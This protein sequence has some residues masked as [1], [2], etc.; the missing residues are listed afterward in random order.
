MKRNSTIFLLLALLMLVAVP[1]HAALWGADAQGELIGSRTSGTDNI[2]ATGDWDNGGFALSWDI[3]FQQGLWT[4]QYTATATRKEISHFLLEV[5]ND[6]MPV[7]TYEGTDTQITLPQTWTNEDGKSNPD[8]PNP[9]YGV[10]F[11]F[12]DNRVMYTFVTDRSPVYGVFYAKDGKDGGI[13]VVAWSNALNYGDYR[14]NITL[15]AADYIVRPDSIAAPVP[16]PAAALLLGS[17]L[18]G[19]VGTRR[20]NG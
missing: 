9:L 10:K 2:S 1:A 13:P 16:I 8:M 5:S 20:T 3:S 7:R 4:Y 19:L 12:G 17:G 11:D 18:L 6:G 14:T 15:T